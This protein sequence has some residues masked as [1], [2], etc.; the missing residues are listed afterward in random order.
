MKFFKYIVVRGS[1]N[2]MIQHGFKSFDKLTYNLFTKVKE[3]TLTHF[4]RH[5]RCL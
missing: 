4:V 3:I 2:Y 1:V 5:S